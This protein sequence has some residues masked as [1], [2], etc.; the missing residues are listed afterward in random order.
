[1]TSFIAVKLHY[2]HRRT[3]P[4]HLKYSRA[5]TAEEHKEYLSLYR[6]KGIGGEG[7]HEC[8][9][10]FIPEQGSVRIYLPPTCLPDERRLK[11]DFVIFSF[12]YHH[13][14]EMPSRIVGVHA[15]AHVIGRDGEV[16]S[17]APHVPGV[18]RLYFHAE[19]PADL[20]T[21]FTPPLEYDRRSGL[22]TPIYKFWGN[23]LRNLTKVHAQNIANAALAS[24][25]A[26]SASSSGSRRP[27]I[28]RQIDVLAN[29]A[30]RYSLATTKAKDRGNPS[31]KS[32]PEPPAPD[33]ELGRL[34]E[35]KIFERELSNVKAWG[36]DPGAVEW[37]SQA[38]PQA[39]F[40]IKTVRRTVAGTVD[41]FVE[42]KSSRA[43][44]G[45]NIY[46]SSGQIA[47]LEAHQSCSSVV[48]VS[49]DGRSKVKSIRDLSLSQLKQEFDLIPIKYKLQGR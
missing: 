20:S 10:F 13:D 18:D 6:D 5:A 28:E 12:T 39:P 41:H 34:G 24:A 44:D 14:P 11:D 47:F 31:I 33:Q 19:A 43:E 17:D 29:I 42:V 38:I 30:S 23:G 7:F 9:N 32:H 46:I 48:I 40:D 22:Y 16:R 3:L 36:I 45:A 27:A 26:E 21:L 25:L 35:Q 37:V 4:A 2:D 1:M 49:F 15:G 8:L